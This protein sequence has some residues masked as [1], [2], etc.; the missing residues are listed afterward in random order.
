M[1]LSKTKT[2][3]KGTANLVTEFQAVILAGRA[4][5]NGGLDGITD[6]GNA[7]KTEH[8]IPKAV[9]PVAG[10]PMIHYQ[11]AWLEAARVQDVLVFCPAGSKNEI[12]A[13]LQKYAGSSDALKIKCLP[14][15]AGAGTAD[16]LR[17]YHEEIK[18]DFIVMSCDVITDLPAHHLIDLHRIHGPAVTTLMYDGSP[19]DPAS[20]KRG[21]E[22]SQHTCI[23]ME[24]GRLVHVDDPDTMRFQPL[25]LRKF[26]RVRMHSN[27]RD[28]HIYIFK[29]WVLDL[30]VMDE[31][32]TSIRKKQD[33]LLRRL[34]RCQ[35]SDTS[36]LKLQT[37]FANSNISASPDP[38]EEA[39]L[40]STTNSRAAT[41]PKLE[42]S[43]PNTGGALDLAARE[44]VVESSKREALM[45]KEVVCATV[46]C[47]DAFCARA[48]TV[49]A[50]AE[51]NRQRAQAARA[52]QSVTNDIKPKQSQIGPDS[53]IESDQIGER[54]SVK[55]SIIG[56]HCTVGKN[57]KIAN[58][59]VMDHVIIEDGVKLDRCILSVNAKVLESC[60]LK[61]C[62]VA[63]NWTVAKGTVGVSQRLGPDWLQ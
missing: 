5:S 22:Y 36:L 32:I 41:L 25:M 8:T 35:W 44:S 28:S 16:A 27:L 45:P 60:N 14:T 13:Q 37:D 18:T 46:I 56:K 31:T 23:D 52:A 63:P 55:K 48:N 24:K 2:T 61:D 9:L 17:Q 10:K 47:K 26:P 38:F 42:P 15:N 62:E 4:N 39:L 19:F 54:C 11:L 53:I 21:D 58:S 49:A 6:D 43:S 33:G 3:A 40:L 1:F 20:S 34:L 29:R 12:Q 50:Y 59:V 30:V 51:I 57:V 7:A